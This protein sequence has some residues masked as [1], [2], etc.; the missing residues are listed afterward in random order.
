[1]SEKHAKDFVD[2]VRLV[3]FALIACCAGLLLARFSDRQSPAH[4]ALN[5]VHNIR[6]AL[7][8]V[9]EGTIGELITRYVNHKY[10]ALPTQTFLRTLELL[11]DKGNSV[12]SAAIGYTG[13]V[14]SDN[15][16]KA[17]SIASNLDLT[18][19]NRPLRAFVDIWNSLSDGKGCYAL[20]A[21]KA[22]REEM[23]LNQK[24]INRGYIAN[25]IHT[26]RGL[27]D[28]DRH[29]TKQVRFVSNELA[30]SPHIKVEPAKLD[31][32]WEVE[33]GNGEVVIIVPSQ[34]LVLP[35]R[36]GI[37][38]FNIPVQE[39][40][41]DNFGWRAGA[42]S[43]SFPDLDQLTKDYQE[44]KIEKIERILQGEADRSAESVEAFGL[45]IPRTGLATVGVLLILTLQFYLSRHLKCMLVHHI[46]ILRDIRPAWVGLYGDL[47]SRVAVQLTAFALP[48]G[49]VLA[50]GWGT[51]SFW[52][53][54]CS[55]L[56]F[57]LSL[58]TAYSLSKLN[59]PHVGK[60][61][62]NE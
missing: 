11:D 33:Y 40:L 25:A 46:E 6:K 8:E 9:R 10:P 59:R 34:N 13:L 55:C 38:V 60:A 28:K 53:V 36:D 48:I 23:H 5:D 16:N 49:S 22:F 26:N 21:G 2:H 62:N 29:P 27:T 51:L 12:S 61:K 37:K 32:E 47:P 31:W 42:F 45:K 58:S 15:I 18:P 43:D 1:M 41:G 57:V 30:Y 7:N 44:L 56:S 20:S 54:V 50:L 14:Y 3:H 52:N 24:S 4:R 35:F 17:L 39:K 19:D